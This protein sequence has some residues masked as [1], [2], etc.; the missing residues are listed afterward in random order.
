MA[1][2]VLTH[3]TQGQLNAI[4]AKNSRVF[5]VDPKVIA[6]KIRV[7]GNP[8]RNFND[9]PVSKWELKRVRVGKTAKDNSRHGH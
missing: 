8:F 9:N 1:D 6:E 3:V 7:E 4:S 5:N 2:Q